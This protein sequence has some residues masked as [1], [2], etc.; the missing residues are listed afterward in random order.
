MIPAQQLFSWLIEDLERLL[1]GLSE[2]YP[3]EHSQGRAVGI[4]EALSVV[5]LWSARSQETQTSGSGIHDGGSA[6]LASS[7]PHAH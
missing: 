6:S 2:A 7:F 3:D 1:N 4:E 5:Q